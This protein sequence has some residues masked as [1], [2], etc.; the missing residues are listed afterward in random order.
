MVSGFGYLEELIG[1]KMCI[2]VFQ[3]NYHVVCLASEPL[4]T[5]A[6]DFFHQLSSGMYVRMWLWSNRIK[7]NSIDGWKKVRVCLS[8]KLCCIIGEIQ[9]ETR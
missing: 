5:A 4:V 3:V 8:V 2:L 6:A 1:W 7:W 9:S